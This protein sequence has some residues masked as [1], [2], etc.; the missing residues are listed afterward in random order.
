MRW[1]AMFSDNRREIIGNW[2]WC[3]SDPDTDVAD[4]RMPRVGVQKRRGSPIPAP[5]PKRNR[6]AVAV[7]DDEQDMPQPVP[8]RQPSPVPA[9]VATPAE[10]STTPKV[11]PP[12][13]PAQTP[14]PAPTPPPVQPRNLAN[15][16]WADKQE[17]IGHWRANVADPSPAKLAESN[18][19]L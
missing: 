5:A 17:R 13:P 4:K 2:L 12:A 11:A 1:I 15:A 14:A 18:A 7:A 10:A 6:Q 16:Q 19:D 3:L 8:V 9:P